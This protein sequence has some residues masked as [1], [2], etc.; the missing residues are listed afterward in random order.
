MA[1]HSC[2][3]ADA[4]QGYRA[5]AL[6][7]WSLARTLFRRS[8]SLLQGSSC[9][10]RSRSSSGGLTMSQKKDETSKPPGFIRCI[11]SMTTP[12]Q[13]GGHQVS[14]ELN[15]TETNDCTSFLI[16]IFIFSFLQVLMKK[17]KKK[18]IFCLHTGLLEVNGLGASLS[19][20][21][22]VATVWF[23]SARENHEALV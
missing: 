4:C 23:I 12:G 19:I 2:R 14:S 8:S 17:K 18:S 16:F 1:K 15:F 21:G 3:E 7:L 6:F 5:S 22:A 10:P 11:R 20:L 13:A 9:K